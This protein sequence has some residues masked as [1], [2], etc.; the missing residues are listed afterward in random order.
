MNFCCWFTN[1]F[2]IANIVEP[3]V[4]PPAII[5]IVSTISEDDTEARQ[6]E[7]QQV[8]SN[9]ENVNESVI[10][11]IVKNLIETSISPQ[12]ENNAVASE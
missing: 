6:A 8:E 7:P 3:I 4:E 9:E 5:G 1:T 10:E 2:E 12:S 11:T